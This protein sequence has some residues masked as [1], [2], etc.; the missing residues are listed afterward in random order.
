MNKS[1][2][3]DIINILLIG[4]SFVVPQPYKHL[5]LYA[6]LFAFSDAITNQIAIHMLFEKEEHKIDL[7]PIIN[8]S[9]ST[10]LFLLD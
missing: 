7:T 5:L 4:V 2:A 8:E 10:P 1:L 9:D 6:G 3:T